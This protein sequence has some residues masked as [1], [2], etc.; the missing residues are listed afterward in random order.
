M[1][2]HALFKTIKYCEENTINQSAAKYYG[3]V[4][5]LW[6]KPL[7][8]HSGKC[9]ARSSYRASTVQK[10]RNLAYTKSGSKTKRKFY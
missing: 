6:K 9:F 4:V 3:Q 8:F 5:L 1:Q 10:K 7:P 2:M